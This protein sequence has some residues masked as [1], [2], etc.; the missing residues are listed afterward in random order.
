[1]GNDQDRT[2]RR[3]HAGR[4]GTVMLLAIVLGAALILA[5]PALAAFVHPSTTDVTQCFT[6]HSGEFSQ[7]STGAPYPSA[8]GLTG[9]NVTMAQT[10]T[11]TGHN[12]S[13]Q[14]TGECLSCHSPFS[15][16][17]QD[18][19]AWTAIGQLASPLNLVG[20]PKGTWKLQ[21]PYKAAVGSSTPIAGFY[22]PAQH[23]ADKTHA[24]CALKAS[25][26][27]RAARGTALR[28]MSAA[29]RGFPVATNTAPPTPSEPSATRRA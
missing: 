17:H 15:A 2:R 14:V 8:D 22:F 23:S 7:W 18:L 1:M 16:K 20:S 29:F 9:H 10:L 13:E 27:S 21:A 19:T 24:V 12:S 6:C 4:F 5:A 26:P 25:R 11:N 3:T 28:I